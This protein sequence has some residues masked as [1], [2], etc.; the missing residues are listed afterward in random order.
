M[1]MF[2]NLQIPESAEQD[3]QQDAAKNDQCNNTAHEKPG[4]EEVVF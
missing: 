4:F 1:L 2:D 3:Q